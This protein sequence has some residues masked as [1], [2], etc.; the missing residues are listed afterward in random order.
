MIL[1]KKYLI[2]YE[3]LKERKLKIILLIV[4]YVSVFILNK[5]QE[6]LINFT[7]SRD[8]DFIN[9]STRLNI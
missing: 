7:F 9:P 5:P 8:S 4:I 1:I 2:I 6:L 3:I